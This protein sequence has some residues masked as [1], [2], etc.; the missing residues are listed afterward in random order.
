MYIKGNNCS[1][2]D[3][4]LISILTIPLNNFI[5]Q[6]YLMNVHLSQFTY[7]SYFVR[8]FRCIASYA[9]IKLCM[10]MRSMPLTSTRS[11]RNDLKNSK[12]KTYKNV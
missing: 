10:K 7:T 4:I 3:K 6:V 12:A 8:K 11:P 2:N 1:G 9:E 5:L